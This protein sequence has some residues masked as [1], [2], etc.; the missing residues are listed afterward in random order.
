MHPSNDVH[1]F[2]FSFLHHITYTQTYKQEHVL[3]T[4][5]LCLPCTKVIQTVLVNLLLSLADS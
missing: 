4:L 5:R 3:Y 2:N 1:F